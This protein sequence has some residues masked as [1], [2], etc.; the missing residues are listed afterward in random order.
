MRACGVL[1]P[2]FS[3]PSRYGIGCLSKEAFRFADHLKEAGQTYWQVLPLGPTGYGDSPYQSYSTYAGSPYYIDLEALTGEGL[4]TEEECAAEDFGDG[5]HVSYEKLFGARDRLLKKAFER[6]RI[7]ENPDFFW[8]EQANDW[9]NDY[10][11]FMALREFFQGLRW[12]KWPEDIRLRKPEALD[13]YARELKEE[14]LF[15][16]FKQYTFYRQWGYLKTYTEK[17][18]IKLIGDLPIYVAFDSADC[19][20]NPLLFQF[21]EGLQPLA[22]AGCPP[23]GFSPTGQLWGNPLYDW[24]YHEKNNF[25]WWVKRMRHCFTLFDMVRIDHFRGF[26]AYYSVPYGEETAV[27]G[28]WEK[29]PGI[30]LFRTLETA[31]GKLPVI[32]EDLGFLTDSVKQLL[33]DTGFPGMKVLQ[34]AFQAGEDS[35]YLPH[36]YT[37]NCVVYTGTHDNQTTTGWLS[38]LS[39]ADKEFA[40]SYINYGRSADTLTVNDLICT[41][42]V[43]CADLAVI[44]MQ[45]YLGLDD[46]ARIN[47]PG[48]LGGNWCWRMKADAF[49]EEIRRDM[50]I[51]ARLY[52]RL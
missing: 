45:D 19:W 41:A 25:S 49:T 10:A 31:L 48:V 29:G 13:F 7:S 40:A 2:V 33:E 32:A 22:V 44:P 23:D 38:E 18:G 39:E 21:D 35:D 36:H 20:A 3:L 51:R 27:N 14:I 4:L 30:G 24:P 43:S 47:V 37:K 15:E 11:M 28:H 6:S 34:F 26:D 5:E 17:I 8:F 12:D 52:S 46:E 9:L 50:R 16:K 1:M 42:L